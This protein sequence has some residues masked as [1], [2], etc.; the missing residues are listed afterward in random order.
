MKKINVDRVT[1]WSGDRAAHGT[2]GNYT[3][4]LPFPIENVFYIE[5]VSTS[6]PAHTL[7]QIEDW[8]N[9]TTSSGRRYWRHLDAVSNQ[10]A[11]TIRHERSPVILRLLQISL[12]LPDG[13]AYNPT[14][15]HSIELEVFSYREGSG[16]D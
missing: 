14:T 12:W 15:D 5:W 1:L 7:L 10:R 6:L 2:F 13:T 9:S 4:Q 8:G 3:I 16:L 11:T